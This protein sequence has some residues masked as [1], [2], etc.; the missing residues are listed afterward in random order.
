MKLVKAMATVGGLTGVSRILGF[1]RDVM[2]AIILGAGPVADAFIVALKLPNFFRRI[3]AEGAFSVSFV[4]MYSHKMHKEG[5][6][7]ADKFA[8]NSFAVMTTI[9]APFTILAIIAMPWVIHLLAPGFHAGEERYELAVEM[10]RVTFPYLL[11]ISLSALIGGVLNAHDK[12]VPFA[13]API[14]FNL[15]LIAA[16]YFLEPMMR[17]GGHALSWGLC[18]AGVLQFIGLIA[19]VKMYKIKLHFKLPVFDGDIK[20]LFKLMGP[21]VIGAG[22]VH[23]NLFADIIIASTLPLGSISYLYYAD[24]LNQLPLGMVGIA[25]GTALLPMLSRA[26]AGDRSGE[27][28]HLFNRALEV[29]LLLALPAGVAMLIAAEPFIQALFQYGNFDAADAQVTAFVLMGYALGV[30]AYV[31]GKV[32]STTYYAQHDTVTPVKVSVICALT[33]IGLALIFIQFMGVAGIALATGLCGWMQFGMLLNGLQKRKKVT[34]DDR[35]QR[36]APRI[37][38]ASCLMALVLAIVAHLLKDY[39]VGTK[40]EKIGSLIVLVA[41]G[42]AT[43]SFAV[44]ATGA[45]KIKDLKTLLSRKK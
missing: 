33:N 36:C 24:R 19:C 37:F 8:S 21:G 22:V 43:Y 9:L 3:T 13:A 26:M 11:L 20:K 1:V 39:F 40:I 35:F 31:A 15:T 17:T 10:T 28:N 34:F 18:G 27:A 5:Q 16:L 23:I 41:S 30:P 45:V 4:P 2:T 14:V 25:V 6:E 29:C 44:L 7:E 32:F 38:F 42:L 12:F